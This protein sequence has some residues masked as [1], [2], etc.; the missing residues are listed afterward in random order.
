VSSAVVSSMFMA[1]LPRRMKCAHL[2]MTDAFFEKKPRPVAERCLHFPQRGRQTSRR[3]D[4]RA[5][6]A[7]MLGA[8]TLPNAS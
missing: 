8:P 5:G 1:S 3:D 7:S 4:A 6:F 2:D